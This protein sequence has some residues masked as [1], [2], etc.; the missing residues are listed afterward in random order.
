MMKRLTAF[1]IM[2]FMF[3]AFSKSQ[4]TNDILNLLTERKV[5]SQQQAD[6]LRARDALKQQE[7]TAI[8]KSFNVT[9]GQPLQIG[10][11]LQTRYQ[12]NDEPG[13]TD[14]FDIRR[15]YFDVKGTLS[16]K[17]GVRF[18]AN[19]VTNPKI[20]DIY[21]DF[22][23]SDY[24]TFTLGQ[25]AIPFSRE[26]LTSNTKLDFID[27]SQVVEALAGRSKD[28]I[29]SQDGRDIGVQVGGALFKTGEKT[30]VD[31]K[32][33]LVNGSGMNTADKNESKDVVTRVLIH[34]LQGLDLGASYYNG[35]GN[36][37]TP[38]RNR[39][40]NRLGFELGY[41]IG[42]L[43]LSGEFI[44]GQDASVK[45]QGYYAQ[46]GY[47]LISKK[48]QL[49]GKFDS[50]DP[51]TDQDKNTSIWYIAGLNF[52]I[53]PNILLQINYT[54]KEEQGNKITNNLAAIQLQAR[55]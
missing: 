1:S 11:Y 17:W 20:V 21:T 34:P 53:N 43:T 55:F 10:G 9:S 47:Y 45:K 8:K 37:G 5:I 19:F 18:L 44:N 48:L 2:L 23:V 51:D 24:L 26:N 13:K 49:T 42:N 50:F 14:G 4:T 15:A 6:S 31:Y 40:R 30:L 52:F 12:I 32:L 29:G 27:R 3:I 28:V 46:A 39:K 16:P 25:F 41:E 54:F 7:S 36:W 33:A 38:S 35:Q 22:K